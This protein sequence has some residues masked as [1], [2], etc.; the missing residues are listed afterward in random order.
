MT[1]NYADGHYTPFE[2]NHI[3]IRGTSGLLEFSTEPADGVSEYSILVNT[4]GTLTFFGAGGQ[5]L[6]LALLDG[7]LHLNSGRLF[8]QEPNPPASAGAAG[9]D[10]QIGWDANFIYICTGT[11]TWKRVAIATW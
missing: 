3:N 10:G 1:L 2:P 5:H 6:D 7:D 9:T 8:L 4:T 11:N